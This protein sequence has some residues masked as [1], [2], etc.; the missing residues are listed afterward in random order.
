MGSCGVHHHPDSADCCGF[1]RCLDSGH[2]CEPR[3]SDRRVAIRVKQ[4]T[5]AILRPEEIHIDWDDGSNMYYKETEQIEDAN[6][7]L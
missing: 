5:S 4:A 7:R 2:P 6:E 3:Q 1:G